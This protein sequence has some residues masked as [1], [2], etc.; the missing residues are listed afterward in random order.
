M[1]KKDSK[2]NLAVVRHADWRANKQ[3]VEEPVTHV[4]RVKCTPQ[5]VPAVAF[6]PKY[7]SNHLVTNPYIAVIV[8]KQI[9]VTRN[10][11]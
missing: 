5:F 2:M 10:R 4:S 6:K 1:L 7:L 11:K 3:T 9:A 8:I